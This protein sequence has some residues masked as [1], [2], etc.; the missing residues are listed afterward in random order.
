MRMTSLTK[1]GLVLTTGLTLLT[2]P[3]RRSWRWMWTMQAMP[4]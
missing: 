4:T 3:L 1:L 2:T